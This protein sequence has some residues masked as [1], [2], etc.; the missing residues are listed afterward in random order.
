MVEHLLDG[1]YIVRT[2][3]RD[4]VMSESSDRPQPVVFI[5]Y[6]HKD[7]VW[8]DLMLPHFQ[9]LERLGAVDFWNDRDIGHGGDWYAVIR[10][11]LEQTRFAVCL[12]SA[13][14]LAS[15]F[16]WKKRFP[17]CSKGGPSRVSP[18]CRCSWK[19]QTS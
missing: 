5:S 14:F 16:A 17:S 6:C 7:E 13:N 9:H 8:K 15:R 1:C 12:V 18:C 4:P 19:K 11:K 10:E 3:V 2:P